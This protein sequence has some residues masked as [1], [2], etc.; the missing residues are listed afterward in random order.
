[1][2]VR[3]VVAVALLLVAGALALVMSASAPRIAG[4]DHA[5]DRRFLAALPGGRELCQTA[6]LLPPD[7][8]TLKLLISTGGRP[9][10]EL[11]AR[12]TA[13]D[14]RL[15]SS[16]RLAP[17]AHE[18]WVYV[19]LA[20]TS[21]GAVAGTLCLH[22]D[23]SEQVVLAGEPAPPGIGS[24]WLAGRTEAER[25]DVVYLRPG[26]ESWWQLLPTLSERF[27][28]GKASFFGD[29]TLAATALLLA[30]VWVTTIRLLIRELV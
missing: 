27:G 13:S 8:H 1:M 23:G 16:G 14:A 10:P 24:V 28:L 3:A 5:N 19:P 7:T 29:W 18:G 2:R 11:I 30:G 26:R 15:T 17:G 25:I 9:A 4:T 21:S 12:F 20:R 22:N 6:M